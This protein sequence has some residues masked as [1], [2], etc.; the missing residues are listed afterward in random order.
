MEEAKKSTFG[1]DKNIACA[2]TYAGA[3]ITGLIFFLT[4]KKDKEVRFHAIQS[5]IF[6]GGLNV[7]QM[8]VGRLPIIN[9]GL[10]PLL[11]L[12]GFVVWLI[13]LIKA[14][15]GEHFK[16]PVVGDI[17]DKQVNK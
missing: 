16:L 9:L 1:L 8:F 14:Y 15:Q 7:I 6:F 17:A 2:L 11:G 12:L 13:C 5:V 4:E 10:T 3:W